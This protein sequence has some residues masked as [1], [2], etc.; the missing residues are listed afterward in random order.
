MKCPFCS[1]HES[2]VTDSRDS[3]DG[4]HR[5]RR[6]KDCGRK[7][8]TYE[9]VETAQLLVVK[10][11]GRREPYDREKLY[12]GIRRACEKR[13]LPVGELE[14]A[15]DEIEQALYRLGRPEVAGQVI[16]EM[17]MEKLARMD[18]IAYIRFASVYRSFSDLE[19]MRQ[20]MDELLRRSQR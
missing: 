11:D 9:R 19:E 14:N 1:G 18:S 20:E 7:F 10:R 12:R 4:I 17:V 8:S 5:R 13:P 15:V 3:G 6:C 16:G 2:M